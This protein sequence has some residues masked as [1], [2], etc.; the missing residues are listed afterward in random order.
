MSGSLWLWR[1]E[2]VL[3]LTRTLPSE[4]CSCLGPI[5]SQVV[6]AGLRLH[7]LWSTGGPQGMLRCRTQK[8]KPVSVAMSAPRQPPDPGPLQLGAWSRV[9]RTAIKPPLSLPN[10]RY[11]PP[12]LPP[13]RQGDAFLQG[14]QTQETKGRA[15]EDRRIQSRKSLD[16]SRTGITAQRPAKY[17]GEKPGVRLAF[18]M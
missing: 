5:F 7:P 10:Q 17:S 18:H 15:R 1:G 2:L 8:R 3:R 13:L 11:L 6:E 4:L 14:S 16:M 9:P 12:Q